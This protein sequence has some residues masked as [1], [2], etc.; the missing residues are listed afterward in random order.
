MWFIFNK[1]ISVS[2]PH[3]HTKVLRFFCFQYDDWV[4]SNIQLPSKEFENSDYTNAW[5]K[6]YRVT[7]TLPANK[8]RQGVT[9]NTKANPTPP[10][11]PNRLYTQTRTKWYI[12]TSVEKLYKPVTIYRNLQKL[13]ALNVTR[14]Y[15]TIPILRDSVLSWLFGGAFLY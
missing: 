10:S 4:F 6:Y 5:R 11:T 14:L 7:C 1:F 12:I 2:L 9:R 15:C 13:H 3:H 8:Q